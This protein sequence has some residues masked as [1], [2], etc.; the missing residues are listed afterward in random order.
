[1]IID[2]HQHFWKYSPQKHHWINEEMTAIKRDF[3]PED[4]QK[5]YREHGVYGCV[6]VQAEQSE[7]E[8]DFLLQLA[9]QHDFI[10]GVVGWV[11]LR[12]ENLPK[13]LDH[14]AQFE[15]LKGFRH[16]VQDE[17]DPDFLQ[18][19]AFQRGLGQLE[20]HGFTYDLLVYPS[21]LKAAIHT[22]RNFPKLQ[23]VIDHIAKPDI[24][25][26]QI[27]DWGK[28]ME[29]IADEKNVY[30]KISGMVTEASWKDWQKKDF[31]PYLDVI[32][33]SFGIDR[34]MF[35]SDW[36]VCLLAGD[37]QAVLDIIVQY[38][39]D[40]SDQDK[41]KIFYKNAVDFYRL[42]LFHHR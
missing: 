32:F 30:C 39:R 2:A 38:T 18:D 26:G 33:K 37:Y 24:K 6:A 23:F 40:F 21:Q 20:K 15:K 19:T 5:I 36:P 41:L 27:I 29:T 28:S 22:V 7:E 8:T 14:Y 13:R 4:L 3:L 17:P 11:D 16:I 12:A 31:F 34:V 35:G 42:P 10:K 9:G 25:N 1:M